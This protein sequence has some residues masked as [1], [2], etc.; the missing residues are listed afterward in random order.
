VAG[1]EN[2]FDAFEDHEVE[3]ELG[4]RRFSGGIEGGGSTLHFGFIQA[5]VS[6]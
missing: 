6:R 5:R 3:R 2:Y 1:V 4:R